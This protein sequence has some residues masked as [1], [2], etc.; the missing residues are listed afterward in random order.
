MHAHTHTLTYNLTYTH[1][2]ILTH[3]HVHA[4][5]HIHTHSFHH[6]GN[7]K[8]GGVLLCQ[9]REENQGPGKSSSR[10]ARSEQLGGSWPERRVGL[11]RGDGVLTLPTLWELG[12]VGDTPHRVGGGVVGQLRPRP[13][14]GRV[15]R[16]GGGGWGVRTGQGRC[17]S[18]HAHLPPRPPC[19]LGGAPGEG[20]TGAG[21]QCSASVPAGNAG[22]LLPPPPASIS[23]NLPEAPARSRPGRSRLREC[24]SREWCLTGASAQ[25]SPSLRT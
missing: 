10:C 14:A 5:T 4:C 19:G 25:L 22:N 1:T 3:K 6:P 21:A 12:A 16:A 20:K 9:T 23:N 17:R 8:A 2:H 18:P 7:S 24:G 15:L 13:A 11:G